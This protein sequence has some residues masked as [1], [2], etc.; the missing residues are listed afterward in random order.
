MM[1]L[2]RLQIILAAV[3]FLLGLLILTYP[4]WHGSLTENRMKEEAH[5]F[6][7]AQ[8]PTAAEEDPQLPVPTETVPIEYADLLEAMQSYNARIWEEKQSGLCDPWS[9]EQPSFTLGD[10]GLED[11]VFGVL[12]IPKLELEMPIYLGA[13][14]EHMAA[15][16]AHLSQTSLPIGGKNTNAVIAGHRG[17]YGADCFLNITQLEIGDIVT[18]TNLWDT[19]T[20]QVVS[21]AVIDPDNIEAVHIQPDREL[22][23]LLTCH[24]TVSGGKERYLVFCERTE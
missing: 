3:L 20:Y 2:R 24:V 12:S 11:E 10:Y 16:A 18:I 14:Y 5:I 22:I 1:V 9:Y 8:T 21:N 19:L 6:L 15:G 13:T 4:D 7:Q 23:T 17:W